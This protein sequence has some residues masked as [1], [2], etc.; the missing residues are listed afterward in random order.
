[1]SHFISDFIKPHEIAKWQRG[2]NV[3]IRAQTGAGKTFFFLNFLTQYYEK[4]NF[5]LLIFSNRDILKQQNEKNK[6]GEIIC[7]NYQF[8]EH[9]PK[10]KIEQVLDSFDVIIFDECHYFFSDSNFNENTD[11]ILE[12]ASKSNHQIKIFASATP[13]PLFAFG[14]NFDHRYYLPKDYSFIEQIIFYDDFSDIVETIIQ[15]PRKSICFFS[16]SLN[17]LNFKIEYKDDVEFVCSSNNSF[18]R[19]A[20]QELLQNIVDF[21]RFDCHVLATTSVIDNGVNILDPEVKNVI[22]DTYSPIDVVQMLGRKRVGDDEKIRLF[23]KMPNIAIINRN[24]FVKT[25]LT[26]KTAIIYRNFLN[27]FFD[28]VF[29]MRLCSFL[30]FLF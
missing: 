19:V 12:Y 21:S 14:I 16:D 4:E 15:D 5:K 10:E 18:W 11:L 24:R 23:L 30:D 2:Q 25:K 3:I 29:K 26:N 1:M 7:Y 22:I 13:E 9:M 28:V 27:N 6:S 8:V 17:A 20:N